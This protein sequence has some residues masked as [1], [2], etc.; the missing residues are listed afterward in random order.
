MATNEELLRMSTRGAVVRMVN[1]AN[2]TQFYGGPG[3]AL[4]ISPPLAV[5]TTRTEVELSIRRQVNASEQMPYAGQLAF[6]YNRLD[7]GATLYGELDGYRP[8]LPTSTQ[9]LLNE[10]TTRTGIKFE[11]EDFVLEDINA[12]NAAPYVLKAKS[13]SLRWVG[14]MEIYLVD[15]VNLATYIAGG[16]PNNAPALQFQP[17]MVQSK[18][19]QP[20]LNGTF[21]R[22][23]LT[24]VEVGTPVAAA[25]DPLVAFVRATVGRVGQFQFGQPTPWV[26][27]TTPGP[28]NLYGAQIINKRLALPGLNAYAPGAQYAVHIRLSSHDTTYPTKDLYVPYGEPTL[29][30]SEF[31]DMP[32]LKSSAVVNR[33]NGTP[34]NRFLNG[35]TAPSIITSL[36]SDLDLRF[37]GPDRWVANPAIKSPT[38]LYNAVVQYNGQRRAFDVRPFHE[39]CNRVIVLTVSDANSAYQGNL[40]FHY[41]API[42]IDDTLPDAELNIPYDQPLNPREGVGPYTFTL[43]SGSLLPGHSLSASHRVVGQATTTGRSNAVYEVRDANGTVVRYPVDYRC[44]IGLIR[45]LG[46]PPAATRGQAYEFTFT[47]Q[48]GVGPYSYGLQDPQG[49]GGLSLPS[50]FQPRVVGNF[51]GNAGIR[52]YVLEITDGNGTVASHTFNIQVT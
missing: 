9:V 33:S 51:S 50:P 1:D 4:V 29:V 35:L 23:L 48:G 26:V 17:V 41:R 22:T 36:P 45:A 43:V 31:N 21:H 5:G 32:R 18:D 40:T 34:W 11:L 39:E 7:V 47:V 20:Y 52:T 3:G 2:N 30:S 49:A 27:S 42:I 24:N 6:R 25:A 44:V 19:I 46:T 28:Y 37:S 15:L 12:S 14:Q 16:V 8:P 10:L 13:E 38:N